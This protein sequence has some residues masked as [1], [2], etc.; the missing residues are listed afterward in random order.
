MIEELQVYLAYAERIA[1]EHHR[2]GATRDVVDATNLIIATSSKRLPD[3]H[4][5]TISRR[6]MRECILETFPKFLPAH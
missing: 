3:V 4:A 2:L 1:A 6:Y 5:F